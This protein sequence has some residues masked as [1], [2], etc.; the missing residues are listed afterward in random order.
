MIASVSCVG[1]F[2]FAQTRNVEVLEQ[3]DVIGTS[4]LAGANTGVERSKVPALA[5]SVKATEVEKTNSQ[6]V[7]DALVRTVPGIALSDVQGNGFTQDLSYR[8]FYASPLQG[9]AQGLA[10]YQNGIRVN[11]GFGDTVNWDFIPPKAIDRIDVWTNNPLFGLNALG[12]ALNMTMKN[13]FTYQGGEVEVQGGSHGRIAGS[14]QYGRQFGDFAFYTAMDIMRDGGWRK[15][16][17]S[18]LARFY[19]DFGWRREGNEVHVTASGSTNKLGVIGPTPVQEL[20]RDY[21]GVYTWPQTTNNDNITLGINGVFNIT[22]TWTVQANAYVRRFIQSH[23]DGNDSDFENCSASSSFRGFLCLEDD[24][25]GTPPG[26]KTRAWRD[27]FVI[28]DSNGRTI[29]F[30]GAATAYGIID[31]TWSRTTTAGGSVQATNKEKLGGRDNYFAIGASIDHSWIS[32]QSNSTLGFIFPDLRVGT[33]A[34]IAGMGAII[35]TGGSLG[36]APTNITA[37][38]NYVGIYAIDTFNITPELALT[39]GARMNLADVKTTDQTGTA[40]QLNSAHQFFRINPV[41][42]LAYTLPNNTTIYGGYSEANRAPTPLELAC[43]DPLQPCLLENSLVADPPLKQVVARTF[44]AG[45]RGSI[46]AGPGSFDWKVAAFR[47]DLTNDIVSIASVLQ[48]RG[49]YANVPGS[50]R[51]GV[52]AGV[53][54]QGESFSAYVN[55]AF[56]DATYQFTGALPSPNNPFANAVG[57]IAVTPGKRIPGIPMHQVKLGAEYSIT[58]Q[59]KVGADVAAFSSQFLRGDDSNQNPELPAYAVVGLHTSWQATK[60]IQVFARVTNLFNRKAGAFGAFFDP[61]ATNNAGKAYTNPVMQT[62][63]QPFSIYG[64]AKVTF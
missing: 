38:N 5:Q 17:S 34:A 58:P 35:R 54:Y 27:Q 60:N 18:N 8:G 59:W 9:V 51:Q 45:V 64:G 61:A 36:F 40:P 24:A 49:Y 14:L 12:G 63:L 10:V 20:A 1:G 56:V 2:A 29:P 62:P 25:W 52:E 15:H 4:P 53:Q 46:A 26:G 19:S 22:P 13:G 32:F 30:A 16:S 33:E 37:E 50:R 3:I 11:E 39:A 44:E 21:A 7:I 48:G 31:R 55:Y 43:S 42:G 28:L 6:T 47:T 57:D 41:V 23:V